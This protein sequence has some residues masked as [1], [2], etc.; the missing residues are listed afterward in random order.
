MTL[1][2]VDIVLVILVS[3]VAVLAWNT[4][5]GYRRGVKL[6]VVDPLLTD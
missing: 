5:S 2:G 3:G 1:I 6:P 4:F